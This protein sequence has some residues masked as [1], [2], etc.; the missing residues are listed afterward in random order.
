M[1]CIIL[2]FNIMF[3]NHYF[4]SPL[5]K[6][7]SGGSNLS[8]VIKLKISKALG[9]FFPLS[10]N[11]ITPLGIL[12]IL[13]WNCCRWREP[14]FRSEFHYPMMMQIVVCGTVICLLLLIPIIGYRQIMRTPKTNIIIVSCHFYSLCT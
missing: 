1:V 9:C 13:G 3:V 8:Q 4:L 14:M 5:I 2:K 11:F 6:Q 7:S 12:G 10:W